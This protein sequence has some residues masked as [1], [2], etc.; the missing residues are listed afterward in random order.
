MVVFV[1]FGNSGSKS[2]EPRAALSKAVDEA[3]KLAGKQQ[4]EK[5]AQNVGEPKWGNFF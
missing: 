5:R 2:M 3:S 1:V 4:Y